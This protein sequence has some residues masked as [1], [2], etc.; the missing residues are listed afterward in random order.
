MNAISITHA[1]DIDGIG[2]AALIRMKLGIGLDRIFFTDYSREGVA[3]VRKAVE[4]ISE[5]NGGT[6]LFITDLGM[7][8]TLLGEYAQIIR[9]VRKGGGRAIWMDHH[10]WDDEALRK[11]ASLCDVAIVGENTKYCATEITYRN[12]SIEGAF[13]RRFVRLVHYSDFNLRPREAWMRKM[14]GVYAMSITGYN[15]LASRESRDRRLRHVV[16]VVSGG[17]F[18]DRR[19]ESDAALFER[20]NNRRIAAMLKRLYEVNRYAYAGFSENIQSTQGCGAIMKKTG[21]D[22]AV[23]VNVAKGTAHLRSIKRD[24]S[25]LSSVLGG[26]GHPHASGF[27]INTTAFGRLETESDRKKFLAFVAQKMLEI[28]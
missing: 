9:A 11:V 20:T 13:A 26:G 16:E 10:V 7:N 5:A 6:D 21:C 4:S 14:I 25:R 27:P 2:S 22:I 17:K 8:K 28:Y 3:R 15:T 23:Y 18:A 24:T 19:I 12:L 1:N